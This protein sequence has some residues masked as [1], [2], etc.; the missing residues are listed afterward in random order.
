MVQ[1]CIG[2][3]VINY[4]WWNVRI[5]KYAVCLYKQNVIYQFQ[6]QNRALCYLLYV[7][8]VRKCELQQV[9]FD[10]FLVLSYRIVAILNLIERF[11]WQAL[12]IFSNRIRQRW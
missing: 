7:I 1:S 6:D 2:V 10:E 4:R 3:N 8:I 11:I 5:S 9:L 12:K